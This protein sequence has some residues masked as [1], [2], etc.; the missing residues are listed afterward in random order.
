MLAS[1]EPAEP[2]LDEGVNEWADGKVMRALY[3]DGASVIDWM[4]WEA[5]TGELVRAVL[6]D[7]SELPTP[8]ANA[9]ALFPDDRAYSQTVYGQT[10]RAMKTLERH[11]GPLKLAAAM[12]AYAKQ[13][14]FKHPTGTDLFD[15]LETEL[16]M[17][18]GWFFEPAFREVGGMRLRVR[19]A[20]CW[21]AHLPR[22]V[23]GEGAAKTLV[24]EIEAPDTGSFEC[25]V[26]IT[27]AGVVHVPVVI[28]LAFA[29]AT[30]QEVTWDA[31]GAEHWKSF[32]VKASAP[33]TSVWIDPD[34]KIWLD[35]PMEHHYRIAGNG[36]ASLRAAAWFAA[37]AQT[38]MQVIGP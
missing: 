14:A 38:L 29:D 4:G 12:K 5:E 37:H 9:A 30:S 16:G 2:W 35:S 31:R 23:F 1:N 10:M 21:P 7:A 8:I 32:T 22:G 26:V 3:G 13:F 11:V 24:T 15:T 28:R 36:D 19:T 27:N 34:D 20:R 25:E 18:L 6:D 17:D 33:L